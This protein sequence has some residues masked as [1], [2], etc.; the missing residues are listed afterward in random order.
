MKSDC[1]N[2]TP[3]PENP[4][5]CAFCDVEGAYHWAVATVNYGRGLAE[6]LAPRRKPDEP[7]GDEQAK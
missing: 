1:T 2:Y 4:W 5:V 7:D 3:T 6:T